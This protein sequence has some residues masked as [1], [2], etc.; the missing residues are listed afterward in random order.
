MKLLRRRDAS[1]SQLEPRNRF[2]AALCAISDYE[3]APGNA[4]SLFSEVDLSEIER[5]RGSARES[6]SGELSY[7]AFVVKSVTRALAEFPYANRRVARGLFGGARVQRFRSIDAVVLTE[8]QLPHS[9]MV[10]SINL[11]RGADKLTVEGITDGLRVLAAS[12]VSTNRQWRLLTRIITRLPIW[13]AGLVLRMPV[14][15]PGLW[16]R[17]RGGSFVVTWLAQSGVDVVAAT[18]PW[19]LG[20]SFGAV[21]QRP[22]LREGEIVPCPAF[23]L[24]LNFD[25][26]LMAGGPA[27]RFFKRIVDALERP[28]TEF[29]RGGLA[30]S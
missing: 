22:R 15:F 29:G 19:P 21:R 4:V 6:G 14:L 17:Y 8:R 26:R 16:V 23:T 9:P 11:L 10:A 13:L 27:A 1:W 20:I 30:A 28:E 7:T 18:W 25:R 12:D 3:L 5:L 24:T 2:F